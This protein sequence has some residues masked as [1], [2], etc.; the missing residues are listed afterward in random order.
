M[1]W[2]FE[3]LRQSREETEAKTGYVQASRQL[4]A[5]FRLLRSQN[6]HRHAS[7]PR[8]VHLADWV[9]SLRFLDSERDYCYDGPGNFVT[10]LCFR[11]SGQGFPS[12]K[13]ICFK[14]PHFR[15]GGCVGE[16]QS[17]NLVGGVRGGTESRGGADHLT[18]SQHFS[19]AVTLQ[20]SCVHFRAECPFAALGNAIGVRMR[21]R[22]F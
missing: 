13:E 9:L 21:R 7:F 6:H 20:R 17:D 1:L 14:T 2:V 8:Q 19:Y 22:F 12:S 5:Y 18:A 15:S 3:T 10:S 11:R 4:V 16:N